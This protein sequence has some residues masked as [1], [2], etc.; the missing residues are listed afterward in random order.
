MTVLHIIVAIYVASAAII[1]AGMILTPTRGSRAADS[2]TRARRIY[3]LA[4]EIEY[5]SIKL[6]VATFWP[7]FYIRSFFN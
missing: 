7:V 4:D 3:T 6:Y 2:A 5:I 1:F